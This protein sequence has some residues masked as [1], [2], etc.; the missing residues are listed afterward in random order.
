MVAT[1]EEEKECVGE[2]AEI[3]TDITDVTDQV[4]AA[5]QGLEGAAFVQARGA[6]TTAIEDAACTDKQ[7]QT[8]QVISFYR[9]G[10]YALYKF[11]KYEDV[12]LAFAPEF[13]AAFFGGDPDNFNFRAT[14][15]IPASC[16]SMRTASRSR[17]P[18]TCAG[19]RTRP[20]KA[21]PSSSPATPARPRAC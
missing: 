19:T 18:T 3:L 21:I 6:A 7:T 16:A 1:R 11:R 17:R 10:K 20:R 15:W 2:T 12:R 8:C 13:Q 5:G 14:P 9:G 4:L